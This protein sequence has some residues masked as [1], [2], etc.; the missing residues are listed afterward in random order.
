MKNIFFSLLLSV[1]FSTIAQTD[2]TSS[3]AVHADDAHAYAS[4]VNLNLGFIS[5][6]NGGGSGAANAGFR[7]PNIAIPG[8]ATIVTAKITFTSDDTRSST[9]V[10]LTIKGEKELNPDVF[11][12]DF[13]VFNSRRADA[14]TATVA[15]NNI[16]AWTAGQPYDTPELKT[17][18]Q[19]LIDQEGWASG[20]AIVIFFDNNAS[21]ASA[22][23]RSQQTATGGD[24]PALLS[25]T[26]TLPLPAT[27]T[28]GKFKGYL[29]DDRY[30]G[31]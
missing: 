7:F 22:H 15:W 21:S 5:M 28:T 31:W 20:N 18:I 29:T 11:T 16:A 30:K 4:A 24:T 26:Y 23:R 3:P 8:G 2:I 25:I 1:F 13:T 10:N 9:T 12:T 17:I 19:E 27:T 14:T 6:G